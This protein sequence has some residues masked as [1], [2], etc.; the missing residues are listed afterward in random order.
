[1]N[2][3]RIDTDGP[4]LR[5]AMARPDRRNAFDAVLIDELRDAFARVADERVVLLTGDGPSFSAG[6]DVEWMRSPRQSLPSG[7]SQAISRVNSYGYAI[8][9]LWTGS[10]QT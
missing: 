4:V 7:P 1:M 3:L 6:A 2:A 5:I 10:G 8:L 9:L